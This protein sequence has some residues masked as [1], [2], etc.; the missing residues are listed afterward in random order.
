V[1]DLP[2]DGFLRLPLRLD[3]RGRLET[4][5]IAES[6]ERVARL[7]LNVPL[8]RDGRP[9]WLP[10]D[11]DFGCIVPHSDFQAVVRAL[12]HDNA[13]LVSA[14]RRTI[15]AGD[16]RVQDVRVEPREVPPADPVRRGTDG[17][18]HRGPMKAVT[19]RIRRVDGADQTVEYVVAFGGHGPVL[20]S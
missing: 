14:I 16:S 18:F 6:V 8:Q 20:A 17:T 4:C 5:P 12:H 9:R 11:P 7:N 3:D 10:A 19:I 15:R 2:K 13:K 1:T